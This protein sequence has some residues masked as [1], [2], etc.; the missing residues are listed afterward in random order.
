MP[1]SLRKQIFLWYSLAIPLLVGALAFTAQQVIVETMRAAVDRR[2]QERTKVIAN[3]IISNP[4]ISPEAYDDLIQWFTGQVFPYIPAILRI[5]EAERIIPTTF[6]DVPEQIIPIMN[7]QLLLPQT[8]E[9]RFETINVRGYEALRL[10]TTPVYSPSTGKAILLV[11]TGDSLAPITEAQGYL[12]RYSLTVGILG[13]IVALLIGF[14]LLRHG[15][16]PL[17]KILARVE[18]IGS[19]NLTDTIPVENRPPELQHLVDT[20][21]GLLYR[22][23]TAFRSREIFI[24]SVSHDLRTPLTVLRGQIEV[25]LMQP[26]IDTEAKQNLELMAR[27]VKSLARMTNNLLLSAQLESAPTLIP[28]HVDLK[29]LLDEVVREAR[30]LAQGLDLKVSIPDIVVISGDYDL[31]KQMVLN[32]V[33]NAI[34]FTPKGGAIAISLSGDEAYATLEITDTG[35][36]I[37]HEHADHLGK[38]FYK[39]GT[40]VKSRPGG[41]GLGLSIVKQ[42]LDLHGGEMNIRSQEG[43]GT[44]VTMR[45]PLGLPGAGGV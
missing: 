2:L 42:I 20:L 28:G 33:D 30:V 8:Q 9:G 23:D 34:K 39:V 35:Q 45:L 41:A 7:D 18:A 17:E 16:R 38:P 43:A 19:K 44:T 22:L 36:G 29:E 10:Y 37:P 14:F 13:S 32:V 21:N 27:E 40:P 6:G 12:W 3:A 15:F 26:S 1:I 24:A 25:M 31:L 5:S 4:E 11:Q